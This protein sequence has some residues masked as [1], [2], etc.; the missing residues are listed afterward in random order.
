MCIRDSDNT[1]AKGINAL[2]AG[3]SASTSTFATNGVAI[4]TS[5]KSLAA[6]GIAIG[7]YAEA[8]GHDSVYVGG[9]AGQGSAYDG[10]RGNANMRNVGF[11]ALA[12]SAVT[13]QNNSAVGASTGRTCLLYTSRCV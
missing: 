11:G 8:T 4:G 13:G 9:G 6:G 2:A 1:G 5:S 12:G 7:E 3:V 10:A